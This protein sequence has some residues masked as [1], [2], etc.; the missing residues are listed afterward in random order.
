MQTDTPI[1]DKYEK[2][3]GIYD[4]LYA[5]KDYAHE[6]ERLHRIIQDNKLSEGI[7]LLDVACGTGQHLYHLR[8]QYRVEGLDLNSEML[9]IAHQRCPQVNF[10]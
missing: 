3:V 9:A 6:A 10:H 7:S 2:M 4:A 5:F 1:T 8:A